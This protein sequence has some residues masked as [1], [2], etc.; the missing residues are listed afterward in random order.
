MSSY[1]Y[2]GDAPGLTGS[3]H[4]GGGGLGV[5]GSSVP[6]GAYGFK[7]L[8]LPAD[9]GKEYCFPITSVPAGLTIDAG[10]D[11]GFTASANDGTYVVPFDVIEDTVNIGS[12]SFTLVFG[13]AAIN[14]VGAACTQAATCSTG[15]VTVTP[16]APGVVNLAGSSCMQA[17][18]CSSGAVIVAKPSSID[19]SRV[20]PQHKVPFP[21]GRHKVAFPGGHRVVVFDSTP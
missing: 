7:S 14:L 6:S 21:G 8:S 3:Y 1:A 4:Y 19:A 18:T 11:S 13:G 9:A 10:E 16:H 12:S 2:G 20:L 17:A 5:L 15:A